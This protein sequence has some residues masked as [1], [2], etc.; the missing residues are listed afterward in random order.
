MPVPLGF[1]E[2][3]FH[4]LAGEAIGFL[5]R[6]VK[7][8]RGAGIGGAVGLGDPRLGTSQKLLGRDEAFPQRLWVRMCVLS[9]APHQPLRGSRGREQDSGAWVEQG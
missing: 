8:E 1:L 6:P 7:A 5:A 3:R 9:S 2:R 4:H